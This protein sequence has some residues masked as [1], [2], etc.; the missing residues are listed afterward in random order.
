MLGTS[1]S[2]FVPA[3]AESYGTSFFSRALGGG[4]GFGLPGGVAGMMVPAVGL[5]LGAYAVGYAVYSNILGHGKNITLPAD[6]SI[7]LRLD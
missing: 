4:S 5:G 1:S 3:L 2:S 7:E 6:T